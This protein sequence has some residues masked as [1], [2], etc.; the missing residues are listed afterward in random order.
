MEEEEEVQV[1]LIWRRSHRWDHGLSPGP[2][3]AIAALYST[4]LT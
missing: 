2:F 4:A 1:A 3:R